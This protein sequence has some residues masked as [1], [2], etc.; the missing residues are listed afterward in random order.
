MFRRGL[1][2]VQPAINLGAAA[3]LS[4]SCATL[5]QGRPAHDVN[6]GFLTC[7]KRAGRH[8]EITD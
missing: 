5:K 1:L 4:L 6:V 8:R 2:T 7:S 3:V